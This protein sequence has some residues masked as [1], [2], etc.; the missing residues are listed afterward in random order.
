VAE[1]V[2]PSHQVPTAFDVLDRLPTSTTG[3]VDREALRARGLPDTAAHRAFEAPRTPGEVLIAEI[4]GELLGHQP[5]GRQDDF[6]ALGGHS[7]LATRVMARLREALGRDIAL[8]ALFEAPT[9]AALAVRIE[10]LDAQ[11]AGADRM[12]ILPAPAKEGPVPAS[13]AQE[14]MWFLDRLTPGLYLYNIPILRRL[15]GRLGL[16]ALARALEAMVARHDALRTVFEQHQGELIQR[17]LPATALPLP[18]I[19]L[20]DLEHAEDMASRL[21]AAEAR[22]PFDLAAGPLLRVRVLRLEDELQLVT[23]TLHHI[24]GDEWSMGIFVR[25]LAACYGAFVE[26]EEPELA[27]LRLQHT[28]YARWQRDLLAG[29]TLE[30]QLDYW[31]QRLAGAPPRIELPTD[32]VRPRQPGFTGDGVRLTL[33]PGLAARVR[34]FAQRATGRLLD[35]E[36]TGGTLFMTMLSAFSALL[37]RISGQSTVV[38]G[39]PSANRDRLETQEVIGFLLN[40]LALRLDIDDASFASLAAQAREVVLGAQAHQDVPFERLVQALV[41][42][43]D[44]AHGPLFQVMLAM[45]TPERASAITFPG[46]EVEAQ[47]LAADISKFDLTLSVVDLGDAVHLRLTFKTDLF[48]RATARRLLTQLVTLLEA[49]LASPDTPIAHLDL[50]AEDQ[51]ALILGAW[52]HAP[53][54]PQANA[55]GDD[56]RDDLLHRMVAA[57]AARTP[58]ATAVVFGEARLDYQTLVARARCLAHRLRDLGVG[59]E[60]VVGVALDRCLDL[61]SALL[62]VLEAGGAYLPLDPSY[63]TSRLAYVLEDARAVVVITDEQ[64][65][66]SLPAAGAET[67]L[68]DRDSAVWAN[69]APAPAADPGVSAANLAYVIYTSGSTGQPKGVGVSHGAVAQRLAWTRNGDLDAESAFLQKTTISFDVSV[70]EIFAPLVAGGRTVLPPP[71]A[72]RDTGALLQ[73]IEDHGITHTSF[74][75]TLLDALLDEPEIVRRTR[76]LRS[77]ITGGETVPPALPGRLADQLGGV[78]LENRYGPTETTISVTAWHCDPTVQERSLPIGRPIAGAEIYLVDERGQPVPVGFPGEILIGGS[79]LARGYLGQG[80]RTAEAFVPD[81][82]GGVAGAR[83]YRTGDLARW[84]ADGALEFIVRRDAQI[85]IRGFRVEL[86][87]IEAALAALDRVREAAV[88]DVAAPDVAAGSG[89]RHLVAYL[90]AEPGTAL[91]TAAIRAEAGRQLP[92]H[93]MPTAFVPIERLPTSTTGKIDRQALRLRGLPGADTAE[94]SAPPRGVTEEI[95][96]GIWAELLRTDSIG[97]HDDFFARG[98]HSLLATRVIA[99][100]RD[101]FAIDLPLR[102]IFEAP[103]VARL[104]AAIE[105]GRQH[106]TGTPAP[107]LRRYPADGQPIPL[108]SAQERLW[109]LDRLTPGAYL[110]NIPMIRRLRGELSVPALRR[111]IETVVHRHEALRTTF[112]TE[113][114]GDQPSQRVASVSSVPLP[115]ADLRALS[116]APARALALAG[117]ETRRPFDL[118]AG[119]LLRARLLR[120][121]DDEHVVTLVVHHII[122]D[123]WSMGVLARELS[124]AYRATLTGEPLALPPITIHQSDVARWQNGWLTGEV[125]EAQLRYWRQQLAGA[126]SALE[127]PTD[128]PRHAIESHRGGAVRASLPGVVRDRLDAVSRAAGATRFMTVLAA[129]GVLLA[130]HARQPSVVIGTPIANRDRSEL[131]NVI[132]FLLNTLPLRLDLGDDPTFTELVARARAALLEAAAHQDLPFERLVQEVAV[133][134]DLS[135]SP[136]FQAML[137]VGQGPAGTKGARAGAAE[138]ALDLPGLEV[139]SIAPTRTTAKYELTL[140]V[141][142]TADGLDVALEHNADLFEHATAERLIACFRVLF[143]AALAD[144]QQRV[145][146]LPLMD[147]DATAVVHALGRGPRAT[148][149]EPSLPAMFAAQVARTPDAVAVC[150]GHGDPAVTGLSYRALAARVDAVARRLVAAG[151]VAETRIGIFLDRGLDLLVA[152]LAVLRAGGTYVPL[153]P[154]F[155]RERLAMIAEDADMRLVISGGA[156]AAA[157][158]T[159]QTPL[160]LIDAPPED[161]GGERGGVLPPMPDA[162]AAAYQIYTSGSTGRPKGVTV[163]HGALANFLRA[164]AQEPGLRAGETLVAVTTLSFDIAALELYLPLSVGARTVIVSRAD[165]IDGPRLAALLEAL[166]ADVLQA[167]PATWRL[168]LATGWQ[169]REGLR[170]L[171]GGEPLPT[172]LAEALLATRSDALEPVLWNLYGPTETTVWSAVAAVRAGEPVTIG[173]PILETEMVVVDADGERT[174]IGVPGELW[175]GGAGVAR[176]YAGRPALSSERFVP[177]P[178]G[179]APGARLYRTGDLARWR[180]DGH[181]DC[182]GRI[183]QQLKIR[184]FRIEPG[185]IEAALVR[186]TAIRQAAVVAQDHDRGDRRLVAF[187]VLAGD[188]DIEPRRL[189]QHL[190]RTLPEYMVPSAFETLEA[191]PLTPNDKVDRKA[192]AHHSLGHAT[193]RGRRGQEDGVRTLASTNTENRLANI[194]CEVL[195]LETVGVDESFFELGGHSLLLAQVHARLRSWL[196]AE[197]VDNGMR[198]ETVTTVAMVDLF[199][200]PTVRGLAHYLDD[201]RSQHPADSPRGAAGGG[202]ARARR[203]P[204]ERS[205]TGRD[206]AVVAMAGRFPGAGDP[207][208]LWQRLRAGDELLTRFDDSTLL[209]A[210]VDPALLARPNYV[211][212]GALVKDADRFDA[213]FFGYA[214]REAQI[215]DPQQ[216]VFLECA[217]EALELAGYDSTREPGRIGVFG[218]VGM[219][220]Y[221]FNLLSRPALLDVVGRFQV[222]ISNDKDFLPTRVSYKLGLT[223][224]SVNVQTAC[225]TSL[226]AISLACDALVDDRADMVLA[227]GVTLRPSAFK[228]MGYLFEPGGI[229]SPDGRTRPF[230]AASKGTVSSNAAGIV[231][232]K[233]LD[234]AIADDDQIRAVIKGWA[235]NND[236]ADK[237][238]YTAPSVGGQAAV[239]AEALAAAG[240][241]SAS[242]GYVETHGTGTPLG[243]PIEVAALNRAFT[244]ESWQPHTCA[245]GSIKSNLGHP[246]AAAGVSGVIKTVLA[247]EHGEIPPS[248]FFEQPNPN[249]DFGAGPFFVADRLL[250]WPENGLARRA[251]VSALGI[252]GTNAHIVLEAAPERP[253]PENAADAAERPELLVLSARTATALERMGRNLADH[254]DRA[255]AESGDPEPGPAPSLADAGFTLRAGRRAFPYRRMVVVDKRAS[256]PA[257]LRDEARYASRYQPADRRAVAFL[258]PGG[259]AQ[260][261]GMGRDLYLYESV[262][263]QEIDRVAASFAE[264]LDR[265]IRAQLF[266]QGAAA[267]SEA[268]RLLRRTSY[269]L[270]ALFATEYALAM[271]WRAWGLE[272]A[273]VIGHSLGEYTAAVIAG[274]LGIDDATLLVAER[275]QLFERLAPGAMLSVGLGAEALEAYL[276]DELAIAAANTPELSVASGPEPAIVALARRLEAAG[277]DASRVH[278]DVAAHSPMVESILEPFAAVARGISPARPRLPLVSNVTG[279]WITDAE[280]RDSGYW[281]RHLRA[282]VRFAE[283]LGA[284]FEH[285]GPIGPKPMLLEVGPGRTLATLAR[286]HPCSEEAGAILTSM[287]HPK[288]TTSDLRYLLDALGR[289]W[290]AGADID[291]RCF[292]ARAPGRRVALPSYPFERSRFWV[293]RP[294]RAEMPAGGAAQLEDDGLLSAQIAPA[295][296]GPAADS[297]EH[298]PPRNALEGKL[299]AIWQRLLGVERVGILDDSFELGGSSLLAVRM[300]AQMSQ[301]LD[302]DVPPHLLLEA[303]TVAGLAARLEADGVASTAEAPARAGEPQSPAPNLVPIQRGTSPPLFLVHPVGGH[304]FGYRRVAQALGA[305]WTVYALRARGTEE[306]EHPID[307]LVAMATLYVG[308]IR[309]VQPN[310]PYRLGGS[311]MGGN[312]AFEMARQLEADGQ[313]VELLALLDAVGPG[314]MPERPEDDAALLEFLLRDRLPISVGALRAL[315]EDARIQAVLDAAEKAGGLPPDLGQAGARRILRLVKSH[316]KALFDY[317]HGPYGGPVLFLRAAERRRWDP[318]HPEIPWIDLAGGGIEIHV[319]PGDHLSMHLPPNLESLAKRLRSALLRLSSASSPPDLLARG[320]FD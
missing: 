162:R 163:A 158:P 88:V 210:G 270:P 200:F 114:D 252:G 175:I 260:Y 1:Q 7:L 244:A 150:E 225:S 189:R 129:F 287:R 139:E 83:L 98:G 227:G 119:P 212:A 13:F 289:T 283:G 205:E 30:R 312:I 116:D 34:G 68:I 165:A 149:G 2:L 93:Q 204:K 254:L 144:P 58:R 168:L 273:A 51:R 53:R 195:G 85:K 61:V 178:F 110:Y 308:Q 4:W 192:L 94:I 67:V 19:D 261:P 275:G 48:T 302:R 100:L 249:I 216:R 282:T 47:A 240:V 262:Y 295:S 306:G 280:A 64:H 81:A 11:V 291:W 90:T 141:F 237:I 272:P 267:T 60:V 12:P 199:R 309:G 233:R 120:I 147:R 54:H 281:P 36:R 290:L 174:P 137:V 26:G 311:S 113:A 214:P 133:D 263:R 20:R 243:D 296:G 76:S 169:G 142:P 146:K 65:A 293:E 310:G 320:P 151:A 138:M 229:Q 176:G 219:N 121:G 40:T 268:S 317:P 305:Q 44:L 277:V 156:L 292:H 215:I 303:P 63:P 115:V 304:V 56:G 33:D 198:G 279:T 218:G 131:E 170:M 236:G 106:G 278:I 15:R 276:G 173:R 104:A 266:P 52:R 41:P 318:P 197:A 10:A 153:D 118:A 259:G 71:G 8:R 177:D 108:S 255:S 25:E 203:R 70:A 167:T 148:G 211:K 78:V 319:V 160:L 234:D 92:A 245:I 239:I 143:T 49:G 288:E 207:D 39:T 145:S 86:G 220:T 235:I 179:A 271:L 206:I 155:P 107:Q 286:Q 171:C 103:S 102:A 28:D 79:C 248:L 298:T 89:D 247:L 231:L 251:G 37:S 38:I 32:F 230:D 265:D 35:G 307:D 74:P 269:A 128:R 222:M 18:V 59:P 109:F 285:D 193:R 253:G 161:P 6:F 264:R 194:W 300:R 43:R 136:V 101:A 22:Q 21:A 297:L 202:A 224:P 299:V 96:A 191:L 188:D 183:D 242:I 42:E 157:V 135:R 9:V 154:G 172:D 217:W 50:L 80:A 159:G 284:L 27:P 152:A 258:F 82:L 130:R 196:E 72:A 111:A 75:P 182:L 3:K 14:R 17:L 208:T 201:L 246:D 256:A 181:L 186:H 127:I 316:L 294:A 250:A 238:G 31:R 23:M 126:P 184:G 62:A 5:V 46:L 117:A 55:R 95:V 69:A 134:R 124:A 228:P 164:M 209:A 105:A 24:V 45:Q 190:R 132:G 91:D 123:E 301:V 187:L 73:T 232:L 99:R 185:E 221:L 77:I 241:P 84:R 223:G 112:G 313:V 122:G 125:L 274:V 57:Q 140:G 226:V 213:A 166:Q 29:P 314:Q 257:T 180:H 87:E 97:R 16:P 315:D 66:G